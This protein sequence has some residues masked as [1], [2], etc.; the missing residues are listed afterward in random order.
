MRKKKEKYITFGSSK[1]NTATKKFR[2]N[3]AKQKIKRQDQIRLTLFQ[4]TVA[5]ILKLLFKLYC[6]PARVKMI[7]KR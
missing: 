5:T 1:H 3:L 2:A 6:F 7:F 4:K